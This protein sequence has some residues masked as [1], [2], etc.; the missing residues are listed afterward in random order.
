MVWHRSR[1][2]R[3]VIAMSQ[4]TSMLHDESRNTKY[5]QAI[6]A[7]VA[8]FVRSTGRKPIV[9]DVGTGTG[10]LAMMAVRAGAEHVYACEVG[11]AHIT[12]DMAVLIC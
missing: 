1:R 2:E 4:M 12:V 11:F 9:L 6:T 3:S 5:E 10:L 7:A 8:A